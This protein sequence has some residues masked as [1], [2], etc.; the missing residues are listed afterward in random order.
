MSR[1]CGIL[2]DSNVNIG[3]DSLARRVRVK[4]LT[5]K[6]LPGIL[7]K[8]ISKIKNTHKVLNSLS[9]KKQRIR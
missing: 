8:Q 7:E 2:N 1:G 3:S 6:Q 9:I 4:E 5:V